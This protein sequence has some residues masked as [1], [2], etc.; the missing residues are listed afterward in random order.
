MRLD[1]GVAFGVER[2]RADGRPVAGGTRPARQVEFA[3][4]AVQVMSGSKNHVIV[5]GIALR[6]ADVSNAVMTMIEVVPTHE[7]GRPGPRAVEAGDALSIEVQF[8][9]VLDAQH[10]RVRPH[11]RFG[12]SPMRGKDGIQVACNEMR[13]TGQ[14]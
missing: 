3:S 11:A 10:H 13:L 12:A 5:P 9:G 7:A 4:P 6:R 1:D 2:H 14:Q 8:N